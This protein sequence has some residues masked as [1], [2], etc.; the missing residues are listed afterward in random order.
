M[1]EIDTF[2]ID[3]PDASLAELSRRLDHAKLAPELPGAGWN[4]GPTNVFVYKA[5]AR[6]KS[7]FDWRAQ[8]AAL[9]KHPHFV[10]EIDGQRIHFMHVKSRR[11]DAIPILLLHG[12]PGSIVEYAANIENLTAPDDAS[13]LAFDVV[14]PSLPGFGFSGP[15][16]DGGWNNLRIARAL[17]E[18][19]RLLGYER[20]GV[21]GGDIGAVIGPELGRIAPERVLGIHLNAATIGFMPMGPVTEAEIASLS[22]REKI[23]F[24]RLQ[25]FRSHYFAYNMLQSNRP[26]ALAYAISDSP[27]GLLAWISE[28]FTSFGE[29]PDAAPL[30]AFLT[31]FAL[32]WFTG[33]AA[34]STYLYYENA[35]HPAAWTPKSNSGV[36]TGVSVFGHDEVALRR[37]GEQSNSILY[38]NELDAGGHFASL[39]VPELWRSEV[40]AFF[41]KLA[42]R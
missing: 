4:A 32:Y 42:G 14:V 25:R 16:R 35:H 7:S 37:Y 10:T 24:Q 2:K 26:H 40:R 38:W 13:A 34:S 28:L 22:E 41:A 31:N 12:W 1:P 3:V 36:P 27:I 6:L 20:F 15:T 8:E 33:T 17:A 39:E 5:L 19:M 11:A 21:H 23:R 18:L 30:D 29:R 9:N